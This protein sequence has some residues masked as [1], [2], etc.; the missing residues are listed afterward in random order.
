MAGVIIPAT[1]PALGPRAPRRETTTSSAYASPVVS[2]RRSLR[3]PAT[4]P[5]SS[6]CRRAQPGSRWT[7]PLSSTPPTS[8]ECG[9]AD[10]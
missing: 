1:V 8:H 7:P 2:P 5:R 6:S 10:G 9:A 4:G 3:T